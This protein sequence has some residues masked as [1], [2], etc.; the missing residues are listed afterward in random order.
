MAV[1]RG[2]VYFSKQQ[3]NLASFTS[4]VRKKGTRLMLFFLADDDLTRFS[5]FFVV[6]VF[7]GKTF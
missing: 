4:N 2:H 3:I 1:S 7:L 6:V 5:Y